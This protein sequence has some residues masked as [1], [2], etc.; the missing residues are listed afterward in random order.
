MFFHSSNFLVFFGF[1]EDM[2]I[3]CNKPEIEETLTLCLLSQVLAQV[4]FSGPLEN[5]QTLFQ[6]LLLLLK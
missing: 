6:S 3:C 2:D 5:T 4:N 1:L